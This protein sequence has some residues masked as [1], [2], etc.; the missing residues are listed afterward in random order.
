MMVRG[1]KTEQNE[2]EDSMARLKSGPA[3]TEQQ[4]T[5]TWTSGTA[6]C[7]SAGPRS[8]SGAAGWSG[9]ANGDGCPGLENNR[10]RTRSPMPISRA[11]MPLK[12][13]ILSDTSM[14]ALRPAAAPKRRARSHPFLDISGIRSRA[15]RRSGLQHRDDAGFIGMASRRSIRKRGITAI[16]AGSCRSES[17]LTRLTERGV[18]RSRG[19][20]MRRRRLGLGRADGSEGFGDAE[21]IGSRGGGKISSVAHEGCC[22]FDEGMAQHD[23]E[24]SFPILKLR[25]GAGAGK[26]ARL[27]DDAR[28]PAAVWF[29]AGRTGP[30]PTGRQLRDRRAKE[31]AYVQRKR[32]EAEA[33]REAKKAKRD[34]K[35]AGVKIK[36]E[37]E[38]EKRGSNRGGFWKK[39]FGK[40]KT[41]KRRGDEEARMDEDDEEKE[42]V[43]EYP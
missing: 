17:A 36:D 31:E 38:G 27:D 39:M 33:Q 26:S 32:A 29:L 37:A 25:G 21:Q 43:S 2:L 10:L 28:V 20:M 11:S 6:R 4:P 14:M 40:K 9:N 16:C 23:E 12:A 22:Q 35:K 42:V 13:P 7:G 19:R 5:K 1:S 15:A 18:N 30:P 3:E 8:R 34:M 24:N 41:E